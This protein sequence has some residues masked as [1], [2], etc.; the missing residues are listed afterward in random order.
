[1]PVTGRGGPGSCETTRLPHFLQNQLTDGGEVVS[2]KMKLRLYKVLA[3]RYPVL[4][5]SRPQGHSA[6]GSLGKLN[7]VGVSTF[8]LVC[9]LGVKL[10]RVHYY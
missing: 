10:N 3:T 5:P 7:N 1:M 8:S 6:A 2:L 9:F 4:G